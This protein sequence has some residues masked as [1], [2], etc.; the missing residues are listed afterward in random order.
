MSAKPAATLKPV[1]FADLPG[2]QED[3]FRQAWPALL[4]SCGVLVKKPLWQE[5]CKIA[6]S[7]NPADALALRSYFETYYVPHQVSNADSTVTGM[8]T[9]YYEPLLRGAR[10]RG[11]PYQTALYRVPEDL[12]T[13]DLAGL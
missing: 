8:I 11:G 13:I 5:P 1:S 12:L 10:S 3:D 9:G 7:I 6:N 4:V 2:W